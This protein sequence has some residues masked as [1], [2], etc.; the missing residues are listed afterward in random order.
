MIIDLPAAAPFDFGHSLRFLG[1][2]RPTS[3]DQT[4]ADLTLTKAF[5]VAGQTVAV[6]LTP[7]DGGLRAEVLS[8]AAPAG[9]LADRISF[10]LSLGDDL[11]EFY[12]IG[13]QDPA[14]TQVIDRLYGYHQVKFPTPLENLVWAILSQRTPLS[15]AARAKRALFVDDVFPDLDQLLA[16]PEERLSELVGNVRKGER[17]YRALRGWA[18]TDETFLR[19]GPYDEVKA[20]LLGLPGVGAWSANFVLIR[21]LGRMDESPVERELLKA[22]ARA[23]GRA[24]SEEDIR[25]LA[26]PY[27]PW[28]GYW[29]HYLRAGA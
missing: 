19:E 5:R 1:V 24:V 3:G 2:F 4:I 11:T 7:H 25:E 21:G 14:F 10:Y 12:A 15:V 23:Y 22:A 27:G 8:G 9:E 16:V 28:Q 6:R 29:A 26:K 13:R 18:E 17:L 20:F